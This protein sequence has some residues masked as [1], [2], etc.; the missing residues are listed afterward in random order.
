MLGRELGPWVWEKNTFFVVAFHSFRKLLLSSGEYT[1][2]LTTN[3][4]LWFPDSPAFSSTPPI[5]HPV[6]LTQWPTNPAV[7]M[8][9]SI[10]L[11]A[12]HCTA[13]HCAALHCWHSLC[14]DCTA[15]LHCWHN[16]CTD[17]PH[18]DASPPASSLHGCQTAKLRCTVIALHCYCWT[19]AL[20]PVAAMH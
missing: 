17:S 20:L 9:Q 4:V 11:T 18:S 12:L 5:P 6:F 14:T 19:S 3:D 10:A 2:I 7:L 1:K 13:L 15:A 8:T 16:H